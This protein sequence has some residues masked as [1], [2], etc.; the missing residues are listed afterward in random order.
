MIVGPPHRAPHSASACWAFGATSAVVV[1]V[2][3]DVE[4]VAEVGRMKLDSWDVVLG[5]L[6]SAC[7]DDCVGVAVLA[8]AAAAGLRQ[9]RPFE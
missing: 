5:S 4:V 1:V 8:V 3:T 2:V 7:T 9:L 6:W